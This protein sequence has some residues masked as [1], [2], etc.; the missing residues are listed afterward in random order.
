[1][2]EMAPSPHC[3]VP[4]VCTCERNPMIN[5]P[6]FVG[7]GGVVKARD[8]NSTPRIYTYAMRSKRVRRTRAASAASCLSA[9]NI[10]LLPSRISAGCAAR[11]RRPLLV[12]S[13]SAFCFSFLFFFHQ[14][15]RDEFSYFSPCRQVTRSLGP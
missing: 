1:M 9:Y 15:T 3:F 4:L 13:F 14:V 10:R 5:S 8:R 7:Q 2:K 6:V 11:V 12:R